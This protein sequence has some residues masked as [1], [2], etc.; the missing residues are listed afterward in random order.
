MIY[1]GDEVVSRGHDKLVELFPDL[2]V[3]SCGPVLVQTLLIRER[4]TIFG[5]SGENPPHEVAQT[6][7]DVLKKAGEKGM[8]RDPLDSGYIYAHGEHGLWFID[9]DS[10]IAK[11]PEHHFASIGSGSKYA[12]GAYSALKAERNGVIDPRDY[13][14]L[15]VLCTRAALDWDLHSNGVIA[16]HRLNRKLQ[17]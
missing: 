15:L 11:I 13:E 9:A 17:N 5:K 12:K 2:I 1:S 10:S 7:F 16:T 14:E 8:K 6:L 3:A 4:K